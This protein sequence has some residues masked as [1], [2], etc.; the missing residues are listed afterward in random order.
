MQDGSNP[1]WSINDPVS[2]NQPR[3]FEPKI[4]TQ[5]TRGAQEQQPFLRYRPNQGPQYPGGEP[6]SQVWN[7]WKQSA[8]KTM[9]SFQIAEDYSRKKTQKRI[10]FVVNYCFLTEDYSW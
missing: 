9:K 1:P 10:I 3:R 8:Q 6:S 4:V 5:D 7:W 2:P